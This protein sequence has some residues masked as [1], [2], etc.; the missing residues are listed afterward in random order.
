MSVWSDSYRPA[1]LAASFAG[2]LWL[3][4]WWIRELD[5]GEIGAID[6]LS[7]PAGSEVVLSLLR[8]IS[9]EGPERY[10]VG[11]AAL[12]IPIAAPSAER[13]VGEEVTIGGVVEGDHVR[14]AWVEPAPDRPLKYRLGLAGLALAA[15]LFVGATRVTRRGLVLRG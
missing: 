11:H 9:V 12:R 7:E 5:S 10:V 3:M 4:V 2:C 14:A 1:L 6:V 13:V 15:V 8:V